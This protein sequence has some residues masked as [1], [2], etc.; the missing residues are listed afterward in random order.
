[1]HSLPC[2]WVTEAGWKSKWVSS[3]E[4]QWQHQCCPF[5]DGS[6]CQAG[7]MQAI[8][9][10]KGTAQQLVR[11]AQH[12]VGRS[13]TSTAFCKYATRATACDARQSRQML[14]G[15]KR[16]KGTRSGMQ[17]QV[18]TAATGAAASHSTRGTAWHSAACGSCRH[19]CSAEQ[20][21]S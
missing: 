6:P 21:H 4:L 12:S 11:L 2:N 8:L 19:R 1:M 15:D 20:E 17:A 16:S 14:L 7:T 10:N 5:Q 13:S 18:L 3:R 9:R